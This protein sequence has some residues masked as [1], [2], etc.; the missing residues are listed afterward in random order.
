MGDQKALLECETREEI[1]DRKVPAVVHDSFTFCVRVV[2]NS[3]SCTPERAT[4]INLQCALC[5][6]RS[7]MMWNSNE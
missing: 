5:L 2:A 1:V 7:K 6:Q 3:S 4:T